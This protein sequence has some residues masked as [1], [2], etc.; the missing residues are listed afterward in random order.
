[1]QYF[2]IRSKLNSYLGHSS[3]SI[4]DVG[5]NTKPVESE[6]SQTGARINLNQEVLQVVHIASIDTLIKNKNIWF[7]VPTSWFLLQITIVPYLKI[8]YKCRRTTVVL[9]VYTL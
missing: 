2:T 8:Y 5:P 7:F 1:M 6:V 3:S 9:S 4:G